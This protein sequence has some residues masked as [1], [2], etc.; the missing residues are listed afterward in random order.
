MRSKAFVWQELAASKG[1]GMLKHGALDAD[2]FPFKGGHYMLHAMV[3]CIAV[4]V[5]VD[6][7]SICVAGAGSS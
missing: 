5:W 7:W 2:I 4:A 1:I 3:T 6:Y